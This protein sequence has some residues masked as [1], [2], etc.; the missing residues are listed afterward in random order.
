MIK[1]LFL[2]FVLFLSFLTVPTLA[3]DI[4]DNII[5]NSTTIL[6]N[7]DWDQW[8]WILTNVAN[9]FKDTI[10]WIIVLIWTWVLLFIWARLVVARW[11]PEEFTKA[12]LSLVYAVIWIAV[13]SLAWVSVKLIAGLN[14]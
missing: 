9:F 8:L 10:F 13:V 11:N 7:T 1:K 5:P 6:E 2:L 12:M 14:I 3:N 4:R